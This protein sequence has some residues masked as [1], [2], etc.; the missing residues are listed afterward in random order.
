MLVLFL[1]LANPIKLCDDLFC[2][3]CR[4]FKQFSKRVEAENDDFQESESLLKGVTGRFEVLQHLSFPAKPK[5]QP[6]IRGATQCHCAA[7]GSGN[8]FKTINFCNE[9]YLLSLP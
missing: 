4:N 3:R 8:M 9:G 1:G 7:L 6:V 5:G 2:G